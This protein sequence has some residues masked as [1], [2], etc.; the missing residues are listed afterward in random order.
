MEKKFELALK[1]GTLKRW[2]NVE[3]GTPERALLQEYFDIGTCA[4][5]ALQRDTPRQKEIVC[6]LIDIAGGAYNDWEGK[7]MT[8]EEAKRYVLTYG[9]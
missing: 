5:A 8:V 6:A 7:S 2:S 3:E 1:W 4:S 9:D